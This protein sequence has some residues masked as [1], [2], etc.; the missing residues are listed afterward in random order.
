MK[1]YILALLT[2]GTVYPVRAIDNFGITIILVAST[3][4]LYLGR[5]IA[6]EAIQACGKKLETERLKAETDLLKEKSKLAELEIEK[7]NLQ[8]HKVIELVTKKFKEFAQNCN[9]K[10]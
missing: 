2:L 10:D 6:S 8:N 4:F 7:N 5:P 3:A 1:K 9:K